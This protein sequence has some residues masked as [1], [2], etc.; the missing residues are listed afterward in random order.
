MIKTF[1]EMGKEEPR[2]RSSFK[3]FSELKSTGK[4]PKDA[5]EDP[6]SEILP[7]TDDKL[8]GN[9]NLPKKTGKFAKDA[10]TSYLQPVP[11][12]EQD[13]T[14]GEGE[15]DDVESTDEKVK[16]YGKVA[17]FPKKTKASKAFN[18]LENVKISKNSI[19]YIMVEKQDSELQM[20]KYNYKKGVDLAKFVAELKT[21]YAH[22]YSD[23]KNLVALVEKIEIDGNDKYS[24]VKNIPPVEIDGRKMISRI[25]EDLIKLLSK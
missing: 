7:L 11:E 16:F 21:Y 14:D 6:A 3:K 4:S 15:S 24:W 5:K 17:K 22:K 8:P 9:P 12:Q 10:D 18:F 19:W 13:E 20:V 2:K 1:D 23:N 25:T